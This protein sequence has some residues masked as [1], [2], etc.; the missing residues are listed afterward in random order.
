MEF[1]KPSLIENETKYFLNHSL[2]KVRA[3]KDKYITIFT[4]VFLFILFIVIFGGLLLY[5]YKGKLSPEQEITRQKEKKPYR[6]NRTII[7][8]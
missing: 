1:T 7:F 3:F 6:E 5:K 2:R 8:T 4:N